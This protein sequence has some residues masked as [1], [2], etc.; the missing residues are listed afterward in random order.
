FP[1]CDRPPRWADIHHIV[2]WQNGG[3]TDRDNGV[4]LC[5]HHHRLIHASAW[6]VQL[7]PDRRPEFIPPAHVD[8][9]RRPRRNTCHLRR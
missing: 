3:A 2:G 1:G 5:G 7:G 6:T 9:S 8:A 4:A